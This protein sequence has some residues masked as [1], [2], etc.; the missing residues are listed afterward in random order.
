M[1]LM[2][3][4]GKISNYQHTKHKK[5]PHRGKDSICQIFS[6]T[7]LHLLYIP[8]W[9]VSN[10]QGGPTVELQS[11]PINGSALQPAKN[12]TNREILVHF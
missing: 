5:F 11:N 10:L 4:F 2:D 1:Q 7:R 8:Y 12:W 3:K 9:C 6:S